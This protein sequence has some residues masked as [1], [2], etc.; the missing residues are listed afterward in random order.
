MYGDRCQECNGTG[1]GFDL[2]SGMYGDCPF[3]G[4]LG[5]IP[6]K[7]PER[8]WLTWLITAVLVLG[9]IGCVL[10]LWLTWAD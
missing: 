9:L 5:V 4:G 6:E 10:L 1:R 7:P 3:C 8:R 2:G